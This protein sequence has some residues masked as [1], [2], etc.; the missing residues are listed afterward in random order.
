[1]KILSEPEKKPLIS[2]N[3]FQNFRSVMRV[4]NGLTKHEKK[5][6]SL[7]NKRQNRRKEKQMRKEM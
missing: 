7:L 1:M 2:H 6:M 5:E 4:F 3:S